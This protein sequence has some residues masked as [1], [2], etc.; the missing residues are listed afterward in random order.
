MSTLLQR[1]RAAARLLLATF[2]TALSVNCI[3]GEVVQVLVEDGFSPWSDQRGEG[4]ANELVR[5][6]FAA[7]QVDVQLSVVPYA[8][9]RALVIKG[10]APSCFSMSPST[11]LND[12]VRF[13]DR[14][15][16]AVTLHAFVGNSSKLVLN[17][18][19][20]LKAG[21]R[22][23]IVNGYEYPPGVAEL[24]KRG[25]LLESARTETANLRK[26]AAGRLDVALVLTDQFRSAEMVKLQSGAVKIVRSLEGP[27]QPSFI[28]FSI[29]HPDGE[30]QRALFNRGFK[31]ITEN[32]KRAAIESQW[33]VQC[34]AFC[35][36]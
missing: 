29:L 34:S 24:A 16:Y 30:R 33:H 17:S 31:L 9:C 21:M 3:A 15:L 10:L 26:L 23:G 27:S 11:Y 12:T 8:R 1:H 35:P 20:D 13:S 18:V 28:G 6:A 5:A 7:V 22:V 36:E 4:R 32:G 25:V 14:P 19:D 2:A